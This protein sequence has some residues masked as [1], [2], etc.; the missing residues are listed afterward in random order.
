MMRRKDIQ[1]IASIIAKDMG[2]DF[3][4]AIAQRISE[5]LDVA[6]E[7]IVVDTPTF[8]RECL[9]AV[10]ELQ[11]AARYAKLLSTLS[12]MSSLVALAV[13]LVK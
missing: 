10:E 5:Q 8:R 3:A 1:Q 4:N 11:R 2:S 13:A 7:V 12:V 9:R 6:P